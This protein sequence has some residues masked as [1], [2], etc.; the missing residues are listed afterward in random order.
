VIP[1]RDTIPSR[2]VPVVTWT[3]IAINVV[4]FLYELHL[5]PDIEH[6]FYLFGLVPARYAHPEWARRM[7]FPIDDY[8]PFL[9]CM[10][11]HGGWAHIIG[12]M[13]TLWIFGDNV[14]DRMG[15]ARFFFFYLLMGICAGLTHWFTNLDSTM[16]TVGA[17]G[18]IAGV[19]GAYF[20]LFPTSR[21]IVLLPIFFFPFFFELPAVVY[22]FVWF[23]G[24]IVSG[25]F[26]T[27]SGANVGGIAWWAHAGGFVC[28]AVF[29]RLFVL[30]NGRGPRRLERDEYGLEGAWRG[31]LLLTRRAD[32]KG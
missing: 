6:F 5:G 31:P 27:F 3:L 16:P 25:T 22:L 13:W 11:L 17:S 9:T 10:F 2:T 24:Q 26:A 29:H 8:L 4:V 7:G 19:L 12:N 23:F 18:A 32:S 20:V 28:G 21:I 1:I 15:H 14:E 30:R